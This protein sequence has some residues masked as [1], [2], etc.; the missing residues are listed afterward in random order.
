M[1]IGP[2]IIMR[3]SDLPHIEKAEKLARCLTLNDIDLIL[4]G[5]MHLH[6]NPIRKKSLSRD[7]ILAELPVIKP[8]LVGGKQVTAA[9][10]SQFERSCEDHQG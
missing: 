3:K 4:T 6:G 10:L 8:V 2:Y 7:K 1:I 9:E 5:K